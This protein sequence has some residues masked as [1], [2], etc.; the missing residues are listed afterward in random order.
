MSNCS[1]FR[2]IQ[3]PPHKQGLQATTAYHNITSY[4]RIPNHRSR[5]DVDVASSITSSE[6]ILL[7]GVWVNKYERSPKIALLVSELGP[8]YRPYYSLGLSTSLVEIFRCTDGFFHDWPNCM[9]WHCNPCASAS[10][11][12]NIATC[13]SGT[14][15]ALPLSKISSATSS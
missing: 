4:P 12:D 9:H 3:L 14:S 7:S 2:S 11:Y 6:N 10:I 1:K 5:H 8:I 15:D 13:I